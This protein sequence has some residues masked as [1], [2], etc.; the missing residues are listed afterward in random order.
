M[1]KTD[2][3]T[4]NEKAFTGDFTVTQYRK[5]LRIAQQNYEFVFYNNIS[6]SKKFILWRHDC[7][8]S[9][10]RAV[11]LA[12]IEKDEGVCSTYFINPHCEFY[13]PFEKG[14]SDLVHQIIDMGHHLGLHFD[15]G[16]YKI[17]KES[18]LEKI[19]IY[20]AQMLEH[21]FYFRP[22]AFS[23]HNPTKY[24]LNY[25]KETY[26]RLVNCYSNKFKKELPYVSD[27][28]GYW[29]FR[30]LQDVLEKDEEP[31]LQ[32]LTHPAWWQDDA[33][34]PWKRIKRCVE[35]RAKSKLK[36]YEKQLKNHGRLNLGKN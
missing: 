4:L 18:E 12:K 11:K 33:M 32:V 7:D 21:F 2:N 8:F 24:L 6:F 27:S 13:N 26:G 19:L 3:N 20:E 34:E 1:I 10:N 25:E 16:Y 36:D 31:Y 14:Q 35:E 23:F 29:R 15:A 28:N 30:R 9:L 5:L 22:S 17:E